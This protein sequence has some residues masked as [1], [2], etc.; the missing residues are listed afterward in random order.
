QSCGDRMYGLP[1][2]QRCGH[3]SGDTQHRG[4]GCAVCRGSAS[5]VQG[6]IAQRR[7]DEGAGI[8]A[9]RCRHEE[10][11]RLLRQSAAPTAESEP[12]AD[13]GRMGAAVRSLS[14]RRWQQ[15]RPATAG[16][17]RAAR[18]V[19]GKSAAKLP[20]GRTQELA[21]GRDVGRSD[22][23]RYREPRRLLRTP[24]AAIRRV[25]GLAGQVNV[26]HAANPGGT[27]MTDVP[28][29]RLYRHYSELPYSQR[30]LYTAAL[31]VLGVGYL[32]AMINLFHTYAGR[33]GGNPLML[34]YQDIVVAYSGSGKGSR[35]E[36]A[37]RG[38]RKSGV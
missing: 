32:F 6:R 27:T 35:L 24:E 36:S 17:G 26:P 29:H 15:H 18:G 21:N 8:I 23:R 10:P 22:G 13:H 20:S 37:L 19:P 5:R 12:A 7:D 30:V 3:R 11:R 16:F 25:R 1:W 33:A 4:P 14:R 2:Q 28:L 38:D 9:R 34:S 31:L